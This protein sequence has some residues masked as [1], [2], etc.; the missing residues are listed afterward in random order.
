MTKKPD[1]QPDEQA[2]SE[3]KILWAF[4]KYFETGP[5]M[6]TNWVT[7]I[8]F[9]DENGE[10]QLLPACSDM[11]YWRMIGMLDSGREVL[12]DEFEVADSDDIED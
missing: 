2:S 6:V 10:E 7:I 11:P 5:K 4:A 3:A 12:L 1:D 8:E 9:I